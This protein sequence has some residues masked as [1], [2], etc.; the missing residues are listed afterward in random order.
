MER[1]SVVTGAMGK[2]IEEGNGD[3]WRGAGGEGEREKGWRRGRLE[4]G[5]AAQAGGRGEST[6]SIVDGGDGRDSDPHR[7][8]ASWQRG[9][10]GGG[11]GHVDGVVGRP[12]RPSGN[13]VQRKHYR[14]DDEQNS[15][16]QREGV[17]ELW[18]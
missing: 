10:G 9:Q 13:V 4:E 7:S 16:A 12:R 15:C 18:T 5:A 8:N 11:K 3:G 17:Q 6:C 1:A 14:E 2:D